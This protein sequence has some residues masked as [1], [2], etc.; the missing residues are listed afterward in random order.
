MV[1][2]AVKMDHEINSTGLGEA[3]WDEYRHG[4]IGIVHRCIIELPLIFVAL[5]ALRMRERCGGKVFQQERSLR[6]V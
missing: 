1:V 3:L 5:G 4:I 6:R 2:P